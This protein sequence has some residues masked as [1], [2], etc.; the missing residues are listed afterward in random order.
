M[1]RT[2]PNGRVIGIDVIPAQPPRGVSTIQG[3]FLSQ[4]VQDEVKR[5]LREPDR[6]RTWRQ[7]SISSTA[8]D[9]HITEE[10]LAA[11]SISYFELEKRTDHPWPVHEEPELSC[12]GTRQRLKEEANERMVDVVLSDM[13]APWD[14]TEGFWKRS[15]S[16]PYYRMMNTS[17]INTRDHAGSM[18]CTISMDDTLTPAY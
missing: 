8:E 13:L 10:D 2:R 9:D 17:G 1:D 11:S 12:D 18:V 14:Q 5:F 15:K 7:P 6:G 16:N 3:N 4:T